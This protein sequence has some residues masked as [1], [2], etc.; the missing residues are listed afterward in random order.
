MFA[1]SAKGTVDRSMVA[2]NLY[3]LATEKG[4]LSA[5]GNGVFGNKIL[6]IASEEGLFVPPPPKVD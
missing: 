6:N 4:V 3:G 1:S 2:D 5:D